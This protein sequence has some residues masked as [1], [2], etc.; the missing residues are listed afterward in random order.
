MGDSKKRR[1]GMSYQ[2]ENLV[3]ESGD[4]LTDRTYASGDKS[5]LLPGKDGLP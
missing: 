5:D 2:I 4:E 3:H 1:R